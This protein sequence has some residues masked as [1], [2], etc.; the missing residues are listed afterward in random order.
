MQG[1][2][3]ENKS[4]SLKEI[5]LLNDYPYFHTKI[6][7]PLSK[8]TVEFF[9]KEFELKFMGL[10]S[11]DNIL[12]YG[13]EY[14]V[15]RIPVNKQT[16][17]EVR[18]STY[19]AECFL[20]S[21][22]GSSDKPYCLTR[23]TDIEAMLLKAYTVHLYKSIEEN[24][25]KT[26]VN[27]KKIKHAFNYNA[28]F[29]VHIN[30]EHIGKIILTIPEYL[31]PAREIT[32]YKDNYTISDFQKTEAEVDIR[33]GKAKITLE[34]IKSLENGDIVVL[35]ESDINKMS[36]LS[37]GKVYRFKINPNPSLI[38]S[39]DNFKGDEMV[40]EETGVKSQ[41][42]WDSIL[43]DIVAEFNNVKLTLGELKQISEGLVIDIGSVYENKVKLRVDNQVVAT[44]ELVILNDR[45][46]VRI[47]E[48]TK[49]KSQTPAQ[50]PQA[51]TAAP[52]NKQAAAPQPKAATPAAKPA[53]A[54]PAAAAP[55]PATQAQAKPVPPKKPV[56]TP[57]KTANAQA[58]TAQPQAK[59]GDENFDYSDFE[60]EDESI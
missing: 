52:A 17:I 22:I 43:V 23:M 59:D 41:N 60:I 51:Q 34:E 10:S 26:E 24:L 55:K 53:A 29:Y 5:N 25:N 13:D 16:N 45:Y 18:L 35:D 47:N 28:T 12:M 15:N 8:A 31:I 1:F 54:K 50:K 46:G 57:A 48:V 7:K 9:Q 3:S 36:V 38:I 33:V 44:G 49:A 37:D 30:K 27:K 2:Q 11:E 4:Y 19:A 42:M 21:A 20:E 14:F 40:E 58:K 6:Y 39:I 32:A 56:S